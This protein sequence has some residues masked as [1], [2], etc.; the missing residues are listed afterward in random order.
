MKYLFYTLSIFLAILAIIY[1]IKLSAVLKIVKKLH[2]ENQDD[3]EKYMRRAGGFQRWAL[4][5]NVYRASNNLKRVKILRRNVKRWLAIIIILGVLSALCCILGIVASIIESN[6]RKVAICASGLV[7]ETE[8]NTDDAGDSWVFEPQETD[9]TNSLYNGGGGSSS[10]NSKYNI[11]VDGTTYVFFHQATNC[12]CVYCGEWSSMQWGSGQYYSFGQNGCA[13]YSLAMAISN[14]KRQVVTPIDLLRTLGCDIYRGSDGI[15]YCDTQSSDCFSGVLIKYYQTLDRIKQVYGIEYSTLA[16]RG[17]KPDKSAIESVIDKGG[18]VWTQ[19]KSSTSPWTGDNGHFML[20]RNYNA[21]S[22]YCITS[23][24]GRCSKDYTAR[25]SVDTMKSAWAKGSCLEGITEY[26]FALWSDESSS[27]KDNNI[28]GGADWF[29]GI[30]DEN[31]SSG[32]V[33]VGE[34]IKL[35]SSLPWANGGNVV[36]I[37][38]NTAKR[39]LYN[40]VGSSGGYAMRRTLNDLLSYNSCS[41]LASSTP[42]NGTGWESLSDGTIKQVDGVWCIGIAAPPFLANTE[43]C[44]N[45]TGSDWKQFSSYSAGSYDYSNMKVAL[46]LRRK[47]DDA[48][49][50]LPATTCDA[51]GH[52]FPGGIVQTNVKILGYG[53]GKYH[54]AVARSDSDASG[55]DEYWDEDNLSY[56]INNTEMKSQS[57]TLYPISYMHSIVEIYGLSATVYSSIQSKYVFIGY[58][59]WR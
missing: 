7:T 43:Y 5:K 19:W 36:A 56:Y 45:F 17:N 27:S 30:A 16:E 39:D 4:G 51:K 55:A 50:Y 24:T 14:I 47:S 52:T 44:D 10:V 31:N 49:F 54:V 29:V 32:V 1:L 46:I 34:N 8:E 33:S 28:T 41:T 25:G 21:T 37:D 48:V 9:P 15:L 12:D 2:K 57:K 59:I 58:V 42:S 53:D 6:L 22:Y 23:S 20:I 40:Y 26:V 38:M 13:V 3:I 18:F 11:V 35:Y